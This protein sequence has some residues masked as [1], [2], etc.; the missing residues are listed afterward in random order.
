MNQRKIDGIPVMSNNY[1]EGDRLEAL[2]KNKGYEETE[3]HN[4][5]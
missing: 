5:Q 1:I 3:Y 2:I 4:C